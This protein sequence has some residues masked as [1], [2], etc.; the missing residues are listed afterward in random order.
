MDTSVSRGLSAS[1]ADIVGA[2]GPHPEHAKALMLF[3]QFVGGWDVEA[4]VHTPDGKTQ[5]VRGEWHFFWALEGRAIQDVIISPPRAERDPSRWALGDYQ[6]AIRILHPA[7]GTWD[8]TAISPPFEQVHRLVAR[9]VGDRIVLEGRRPDGRPQR[10][11]FNDITPDRLRWL[12]E[13]SSDGGATWF[14]EE[15]MLLTRQRA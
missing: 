3:G 14:L 13:V 8:V 7:D 10:W 4:K 2:R 5:T 6:T 15:E 9:K 12:G 1:F 11:S